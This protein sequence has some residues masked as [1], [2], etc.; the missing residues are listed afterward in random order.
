MEGGKH[1]VEDAGVHDAVEVEDAD[2]AGKEL[3]DGRHI[4][5]SRLLG[6]VR[7]ASGT[8]AGGMLHQFHNGRIVIIQG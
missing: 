6:V 1:V 5:W 3:E 7:N 2:V 4:N 8:L